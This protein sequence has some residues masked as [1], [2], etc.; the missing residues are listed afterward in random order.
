MLR[1]NTR[2][3]LSGTWHSANSIDYFRYL[4]IVPR[5]KEEQSYTL[6]I[7]RCHPKNRSQFGI[8]SFRRSVGQKECVQRQEVAHD[9]DGECLLSTIKC[10]WRCG[11]TFL[12]RSKARRQHQ[13][14]QR[15]RTR[16]LLCFLAPAGKL[17]LGWTQ[18]LEHF[19]RLEDHGF[20][21]AGGSP[22]PFIAFKPHGQGLC[23]G[24]SFL[25][26]EFPYLD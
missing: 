26:S 7:V 6:L 22:L 23:G 3:I 10:I 20:P 12:L 17:H 1:I 19:L 16:E 4:Y 13:S 11:E 25:G 14:N 2:G 15:A 21:G 8:P 5:M 24:D 9:R 18:G